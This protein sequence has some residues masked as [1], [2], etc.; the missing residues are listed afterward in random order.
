M[1]RPKPKRSQAAG[2]R[3]A[4][5]GTSD[6]TPDSGST[7]HRRSTAADVAVYALKHATARLVRSQKA[8]LGEQAHVGEAPSATRRWGSVVKLL[9]NPLSKWLLDE[10]SH[11]WWRAPTS[12]S[13]IDQGQYSL[14][15]AR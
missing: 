6:I 12:G 13:P 7:S 4:P 14:D 3:S 8:V 10:C 15:R 1:A 11:R 5:S 2:G 9:R